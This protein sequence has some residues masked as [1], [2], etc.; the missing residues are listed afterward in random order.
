MSD[1]KISKCPY[2]QSELS[3]TKDQ[4]K[5]TQYAHQRD[6]KDGKKCTECDYEQYVLTTVR[7]RRG[8]K[9]QIGNDQRYEIIPS[10]AMVVIRG[11]DRFIQNSV[12]F[13]DKD[14]LKSEIK[15][16]EEYRDEE[17]YDEFYLII[18]NDLPKT[19][20]ID[21]NFYDGDED[22]DEI[23]D[24]KL[25]DDGFQNLDMVRRNA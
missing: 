2:C 13:G 9:A 16:A 3:N 1:G 17:S 5:R 10:G 25:S 14:V 12:T 4:T 23:A 19:I 20:K 18:V 7:D 6:V 21:D 22:L 15:R 8:A 24:Y 11:E